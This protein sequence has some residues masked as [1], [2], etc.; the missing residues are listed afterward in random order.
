MVGAISTVTP[1]YNYSGE[2]TANGT[3][4]YL[5]S[6]DDFLLTATQET[7]SNSLPDG[8]SVPDYNTQYISS[9]FDTDI[10][11]DASTDVWVTFVTEEVATL[12]VLGFTPMI[13]IIH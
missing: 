2:H 9:G 13:L 11:I 1:I 12:N 8:Y 3:S 7:I 5:E 10:Q 4:L 6:P